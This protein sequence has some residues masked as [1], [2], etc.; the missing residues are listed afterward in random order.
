M[1]LLCF[2]INA[3]VIVFHGTQITQTKA[4]MTADLFFYLRL[5]RVANKKDLQSSAL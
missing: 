3:N 5:Y 2:S 4:Q 1:I